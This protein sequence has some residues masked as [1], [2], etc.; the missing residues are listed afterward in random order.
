[1]TVK[2][3]TIQTHKASPMPTHGLVAPMPSLNS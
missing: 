1:M 3:T 2:I